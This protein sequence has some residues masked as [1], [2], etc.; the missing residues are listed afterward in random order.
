MGLLVIAYFLA[1][2][3]WL[4]IGVLAFG[5]VW[6]IGLVL[7]WSWIPPLAFFA[8]YL[9]AAAGFLLDLS[10]FYLIPA[11]VFALLAWDLTG[12]YDRLRL[13]SPEDDLSLL[14]KR[15]LVRL[16][17]LALIGVSFSAVALALHLKSSLEW[18]IVLV[19]F[20]V[21]AI[22]KVVGFLQKKDA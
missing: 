8:S 7:R 6:T 9:S 10:P 1:G 14:E 2:L 12:F 19:F 21:W 15:H 22:G 11:A 17:P 3:N 5:I 13:A 16:L 4:A 20:S 18:M